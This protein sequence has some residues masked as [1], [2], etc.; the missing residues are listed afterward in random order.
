MFI[1]IIFYLFASLN[2]LFFSPELTILGQLTV[3]VEQPQ[4]LAFFEQV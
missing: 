4:V 1:T 3:L 2:L